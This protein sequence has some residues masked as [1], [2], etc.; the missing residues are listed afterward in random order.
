MV[1]KSVKGTKLRGKI[2]RA[3]TTKAASRLFALQDVMG[4]TGDFWESL[5]M[6]RREAS[7]PMH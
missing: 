4:T 5:R 6:G 3:L 7:G 2:P 1:F